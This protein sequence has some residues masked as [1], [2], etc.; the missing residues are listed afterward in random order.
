MVF[1]ELYTAKLRLKH[2]GGETLRIFYTNSSGMI[3]VIVW[4]T[5]AAVA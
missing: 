1:F 2:K 4:I 3:V 5:N